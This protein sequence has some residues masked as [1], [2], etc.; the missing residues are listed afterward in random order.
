M[1]K[2]HYREWGIESPRYWGLLAVLAAIVAVGGFATLYME[3]EGHWVTGMTNQVVWGTPHVFAIFLIVAA[4]GALNV[5]SIG[6]VFGQK[7][8]KPLARLSGLMAITLLVG[9]LI[10]L[11]LDLGQPSRLIVAMTTYNFKSIFAWNIYLYVGFMAIVAVYLFTMME[12]KA[13]RF[14]HGVG[15]FAFVWRLALTT[16]TGSIFGFLVAR[17]GYDAAIMAPMFI[18]MS[19]AYGLALYLLVLM[20]TFDSDDR[21]L[22]DAV[23]RRLKNLLGV[24]V[25]AVFYFTVV[26]HLTNLYGTENH[27]FEAFILRDGGVYTWTFWIGW[28]LLGMLAPMGILFHPAL[29]MQRGA[30]TIAALLVVAGGLSAIYVIVI[31]GQAFPLNMFPGHTIIASG[32]YDGVEGIAR[33]YSPSLPEF[34]LGVA[35]FALALLITFIGVRMLQFLPTS[36]ADDVADK[37]HAE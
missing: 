26:Y 1:N 15:V 29:G 4:S 36:L 25:A 9:G 3:H 18:I 20:F 31:G 37:Q 5:A 14:S 33:H 24:F 11:V 28:V 27:A 22:G 32:Y 16:G 30:I 21:P 34:L 35:G 6:S 7:M 23:L 13:N 19:F 12:R 17:Q 10:V 8:Y 2:I